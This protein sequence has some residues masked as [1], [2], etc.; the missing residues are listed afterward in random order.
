MITGRGRGHE[1]T[2]TRR[3]SAV[4]RESGRVEIGTATGK[5]IVTEEQKTAM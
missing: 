2:M 5:E 1:T 3:E 4:G